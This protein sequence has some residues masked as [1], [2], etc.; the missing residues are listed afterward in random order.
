MALISSENTCFFFLS[1]DRGRGAGYCYEAMATLGV[2]HDEFFVAIYVAFEVAKQG[3]KERPESI[4]MT[5]TSSADLSRDANAVGGRRT[6][7]LLK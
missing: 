3:F 5:P 6:S 4:S 2:G 1:F 7:S